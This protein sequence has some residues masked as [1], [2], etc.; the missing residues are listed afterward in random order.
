M[1]NCCSTRADGKGSYARLATSVDDTESP[2]QTKTQF[3]RQEPF[4]EQQWLCISAPELARKTL[5]PCAKLKVSVESWQNLLAWQVSENSFQL[6]SEPF[7]MIFLDDTLVL[8]TDPEKGTGPWNREHDLDILMLDSMVRLQVCDAVFGLVGF[9]EFSI[10]DLPWE[11]VIKGWLELRF[12]D[13]LELTSRQRYA[14]HK[15]RRDEFSHSKK[16]QYREEARERFLEQISSNSGNCIG[17]CSHEPF[18]PADTRHNAGELLI[19]LQLFRSDAVSHLGTCLALALDAPKPTYYKR[20]PLHAK[21]VRL[22]LQDLAD[23]LGDIQRI[24]L[25]VICSSIFYYFA[26]VFC[27]R[28]SLLSGFILTVLLSAWIY[29][30]LVWI[31][32]PVLP[33]VLL[34]LLSSDEARPAMT[35]GG[36]NASFSQAGFQHV[37]A[38]RSVDD[39]VRFLR[40]LIE[41]DLKGKVLDP[42]RLEIYATHCFSKE[43]QLQEL[44]NALREDP[45]TCTTSELSSGSLVL[46]DSFQRARVEHV[47]DGPSEKLR[48]VHV[49]YDADGS[50]EC[51]LRSRVIARLDVPDIPLWV[52]P[53]VIEVQLASA[54]ETIGGF[55][56]ALRSVADVAARILSWTDP[57]A[58]VS[59]SIVV[60]LLTF[61]ILQAILFCGIEAELVDQNSQV[62]RVMR[63]IYDLP[64]QTSHCVWY[65]ATV[66]LTLAFAWN[67]QWFIRCRL[68][69]R[70]CRRRLC[71]FRSAPKCWAFFRSE[72]ALHAS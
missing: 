5:G 41:E 24:T 64:S 55:S 25:D 58:G 65:T 18:V 39:L 36:M 44:R 56:E 69:F 7:L 17:A 11:S 61:S 66:V 30:P 22:D 12:M 14:A 10:G 60:L 62:H 59:M 4:H 6:P 21:E 31:A 45:Q 13:N 71:L 34:L 16:H 70:V 23:E 47:S 43:V 37:L 20:T 42:Q 19:G 49:R 1:K 9:V 57:W 38:W 3:F 35:T 53:D 27:W 54:E 63:F 33:A 2:S 28:R 51:V 26:F 40:R 29:P 46:V 50:S 8:D 32:L 52:I 68:L 67:A 48:T 72:P 15:A